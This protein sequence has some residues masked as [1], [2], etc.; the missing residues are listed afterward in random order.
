[1]LPKTVLGAGTTDTTASDP[2][3]PVAFL[4]AARN[5]LSDEQRYQG[6]S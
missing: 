5:I 4:P 3:Q 1:M 2:K 6:E